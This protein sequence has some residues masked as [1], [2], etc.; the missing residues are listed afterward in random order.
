MLGSRGAALLLRYEGSLLEAKALGK[1]DGLTVSGF[2][3]FLPCIVEWDP[4]F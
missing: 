2:S 3:S 1:S 4:I